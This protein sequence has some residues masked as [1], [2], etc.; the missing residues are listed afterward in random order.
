[1]T[2]AKFWSSLD[3]DA[4]YEFVRVLLRHCD[5]LTAFA[6]ESEMHSARNLEPPQPDWSFIGTPAFHMISMSAEQFLP[7]K[8]DVTQDWAS[9]MDDLVN[10][11]EI[12]TENLFALMADDE[13]DERPGVFKSQ[14]TSVQ[15]M[16]KYGHL[17]HTKKN[18]DSGLPRLMVMGHARH[19]KDTVC[20]IMEELYGLQWRS[21]SAMCAEKVICEIIQGEDG[22]ENT[23]RRDFLESLPEVMREK[24]LE[25][26]RKYRHLWDEH[27][28]R[29]RRIKELPNFVEWT[30]DMRVDF[31]ELWY[32]AIRWYNWEDPT[33][34]I[35]EIMDVYDCYC[36]IRDARELTACWNSGLLDDIIW[37]DASKRM[38]AESP[39]SISVQP[40][41]ATLHLDNNHSVDQLR[42]AIVQLMWGRYGLIPNR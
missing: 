4:R 16:Q 1:M 32:Q 34:L 15:V 3:D 36:G 40:W 13:D 9:A 8:T 29:T 37:V 20:S 5:D 39:D 7:G 28:N 33:Q 19:G 23:M 22:T 27:V 6:Y 2:M 21:S 24:M 25:D 35:R 38:P 11:F 42:T 12:P 14:R 41:H 31:R 17:L 10:A 18:N 26:I 30:F